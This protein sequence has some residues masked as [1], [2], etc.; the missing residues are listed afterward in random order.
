MSQSLKDGLPVGAGGRSNRRAGLQREQHSSEDTGPHSSDALG[1]RRAPCPSLCPQQAI[2]PIGL[3][4]NSKWNVNL[5]T[6][7]HCVPS[8]TGPHGRGGKERR[9]PESRWAPATGQN[10]GG[11][12]TAHTLRSVG[13]SIPPRR[14]MASLHQNTTRTSGLKGQV[15]REGR[16]PAVR[17]GSVP[18]T[19]RG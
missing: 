18:K 7:V 12:G 17:P 11:P 10:P 14:V 9:C 19:A 3:W 2:K 16:L 15:I 5:L 4:G 1:H 6:G 8:V 13:E